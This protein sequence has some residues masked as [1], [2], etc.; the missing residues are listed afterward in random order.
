MGT[1]PIHRVLVR[2]C[3]CPSLVWSALK[4]VL[5]LEVAGLFFKLTKTEPVPVSLAGNR[6]PANL[7]HNLHCACARTQHTPIP[8]A[9]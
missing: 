6:P 1:K 8:A 7:G 5:M 2:T 9:W 3:T 4:Y